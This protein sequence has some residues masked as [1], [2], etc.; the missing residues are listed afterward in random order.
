MPQTDQ[1]S[2]QNTVEKLPNRHRKSSG[3]KES[4]ELA[5]LFARVESGERRSSACSELTDNCIEH[6][7]HHS[8][9][10]TSP[11][12]NQKGYRNIARAAHGKNAKPIPK[13]QM[14]AVSVGALMLLSYAGFKLF[15]KISETVGEVSSA[16]GN[17]S[18]RGNMIHPG[19]L[20]HPGTMSLHPAQFGSNINSSQEMPGFRS[21]LPG[22]NAPGY[23]LPPAVP[24]GF[25]VQRQHWH[26]HHANAAGH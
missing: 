8:A 4:K 21:S 14:I 26:Q 18:E 24:H 13:A 1:W 19:S 12:V 6:R 15:E 3:V 25:S 10:S 16:V 22:A 23:T 2:D 17:T 20:I 11:T 9:Q 5:D 7:R